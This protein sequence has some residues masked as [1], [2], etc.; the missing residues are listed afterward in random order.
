MEAILDFVNSTGF[1]LFTQGDNWKCLVMLVIACFLLY[2]GIVKKFEPLL[3]VPIAFGM[4]ITNLPGANMFHEIFF[5]GGHIHWDLI[6]GSPVTQEFINELATAK[7]SDAVLSTATVGQSIT[8]G[9]VDILYLGVKLGIYPCLIFM[10]VGAMTDFGPLIAN[11]KSLLLG[12]AA[13]LG[14]FVTF[15]GCRLS[16]LFTSAQAGSI[17][18][19]GG[20]DGPTAIFVSTLLAPE[21]LGPIAVAAYSYMALVP[22][23]Q[24]PIM[25]LLT[26]EEERKIVMKPLRQVSK[27]EKII[28]PIM[29]A[30]FVALLVPS[31]AP[32]IACLMLGNLFKECGVVERLSKTVQNEL[33]NIV[34]IFLGVSVGCTATGRTFLSLQTIAIMVMGVVAFGFGT[35][36][37]VIL[38]KIMNL[39]LKEKINPLIGSAGVS[40][41]PMA[42]RVS[43]VEGQKAN[44][45]NF[46][47]MHAMGPNVAGVIGSAIAAGV[48]ISLFG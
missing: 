22:V 12:A 23:I 7:V 14:I 15:V 41:V 20:A 3:L 47:L 28:F 43:Q 30:I 36:G 24:P 26:T 32:L 21:L 4:L 5:A 17:G 9:L 39:F 10:G 25:R 45:S 2:L 27:K 37:G 6:G 18:I 46:L 8:P 38:A 44:P 1:A 13:Q 35:A 16:G 19:I 11:P 29:V 33:I 42:A 48:M 31:A 40:A 34:T